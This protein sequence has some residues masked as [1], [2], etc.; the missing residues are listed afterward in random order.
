M[1]TMVYV[2]DNTVN[3]LLT[4]VYKLPVFVDYIFCGTFSTRNTLKNPHLKS[5]WL[6]QFI[7]FCTLLT[8]LLS[9]ATFKNLI[10]YYY[11]GDV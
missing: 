5:L 4:T 10:T 1:T 11:K 2:G 6:R 9:T 3:Y 7:K 8:S